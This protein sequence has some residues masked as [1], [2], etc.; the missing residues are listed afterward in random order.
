MQR[1]SIKD[2]KKVICKKYNIQDHQI[3]WLDTKKYL[4]H[5]AYGDLELHLEYPVDL[6]RQIIL[7]K[8]LD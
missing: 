3:L 5:I 4:A 2:I 8:L 7:E 6:K 1:T